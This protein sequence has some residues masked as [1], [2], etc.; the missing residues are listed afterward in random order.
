MWNQKLDSVILVSPFLFVTYCHSVIPSSSSDLL[1]VL[2]QSQ[3]ATFSVWICQSTCSTARPNK[4]NRGL[5][6]LPRKRPKKIL[7]RTKPWRKPP[8]SESAGNILLAVHLLMQHPLRSPVTFS[9]L[10]ETSRHLEGGRHPAPASGPCHRGTCNAWDELPPRGAF[11]SLCIVCWKLG[12]PTWTWT[13]GQVILTQLVPP[14]I[15]ISSVCKMSGNSASCDHLSL[16]SEVL[17]GHCRNHCA[18]D[19]N[20]IN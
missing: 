13:F 6:Q 3:G 12:Q 10:G 16:L 1:P 7:Q 20:C 5:T 2:P 11:L 8:I 4:A 19:I 17:D 9:H 18:I 14:L 15:S